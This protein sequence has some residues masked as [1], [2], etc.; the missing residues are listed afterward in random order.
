MNLALSAVLILYLISPGFVVR[1]AFLKGP[2]SRQN[3][4]PSLSDEIFWSIIPAFII[5]LIGIIVL[6]KISA[7]RVSFEILYYLL[8]SLPPGETIDF[9][10]LRATAPVFLNYTAATLVFAALIGFAARKVVMHFGL[11]QKLSLFRI[12][13]EWYYLL[14]GKILKG[15]T[16]QVDFVQID[17]LVNTSEG[18]FIYCGILHNFTLTRDGG[19]DRLY[20]VNVYRRQLSADI[21]SFT[22]RASLDDKVFDQRYYNMP[23]QYFVLP[24]KEAL[25]VNISYYAIED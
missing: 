20:L 7:I 24:Y 17:A 23:G 2:Y 12:N 11:D 1:Y 22:G 4:K 13:N 8:T 10:T 9:G 15:K 3:F 5:H 6:E 16:E 14:S 18:N 21:R 25:N 19:L